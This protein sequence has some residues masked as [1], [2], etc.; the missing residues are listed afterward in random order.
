MACAIKMRKALQVS[1]SVLA[2]KSMARAR[3]IDARVWP[4]AAACCMKEK[5]CCAS[6]DDD[7]RAYDEMASRSAGYNCGVNASCDTK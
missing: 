1:D 7:L 6:N 2:A 4:W 5:L 3:H